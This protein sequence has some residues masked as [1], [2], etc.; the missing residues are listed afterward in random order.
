MTATTT[1]RSGRR[2]LFAGVVLV[3]LV[4]LFSPGSAVPPASLVSDKV[5]HFA[6]FVALAA[7]GRLA[8]VRVV[9]LLGG[10]VVYAGA[11]EVLQAVLP[12]ERDG[13]VLDTIADVC[14]VVTG[15]ALT[16]VRQ[17]ARQ[18]KV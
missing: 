8:G 18:S 5:V 17:R 7:T 16:M 9:V 2:L 12:I 11:S 13:D 14:G 4:V 6:L 15:L 10:L 1:K 3:S